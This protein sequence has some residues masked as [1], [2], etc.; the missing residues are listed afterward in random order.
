MAFISIPQNE[1]HKSCRSF[2]LDCLVKRQA[3]QLQHKL[4]LLYVQFLQVAYF[5]LQIN[6]S[7]CG[8]I[9]RPSRAFQNLQSY[10]FYINISFFYY[11]G[12]GLLARF[13]IK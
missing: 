6:I 9:R 1:V 13:D 3:C 10:I 2:V 7:C 8:K 5:Q 12:L 4:F 11:Q